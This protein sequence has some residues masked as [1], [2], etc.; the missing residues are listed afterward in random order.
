MKYFAFIIGI[1][2]ICTIAVAQ[3]NDMLQTE[4]EEEYYQRLDAS[5][6]KSQIYIFFNNEPCSK[7]PQAIE[8]IEEIYN[9]NYL[10]NYEL[11]LINYAEDTNSDFIEKYNLTNPLEVVMVDVENATPVGYQ[12]IEGLQNMTNNPE[13]FNQF[14]ITQVNAYLQNS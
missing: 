2:S 3:E 9:Q 4:L 5:P 10:N 11:F 6:D 8:M 7:C 1:F 14:F 12:K 13:A